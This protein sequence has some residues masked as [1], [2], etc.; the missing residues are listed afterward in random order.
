MKIGLVTDSLRMP[1]CEAVS[2][3]ASLGVDGIQPYVV[4]GDMAAWTMGTTRRRELRA[5]VVDA[6]LEFASVCGDL[7]GGF[8][9]PEEHPWRI[10]RTKHILDLAAEW[11]APVVTSHIGVVPREPNATRETLVRAMRAVGVHAKAAG[12]AY[13][14]ETGP[15]PAAVLRGFLEEVADPWIKVNYDPANMV[16][17]QGESASEAATLLAPYLVHTHA[18][19]GRQNRRLEANRLYQGFADLDESFLKTLDE[20]FVELPLG[21]GSV[22]FPRYLRELRRLGYD[23]YLTIER[24]AGDHRCEDV[25]NAVASLRGWLSEQPHQK[26]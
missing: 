11:T 26:A 25:R 8:T 16:M 3:A 6:G 18:K 17:I 14:L 9:R 22:D 21:E 19:D 13:A 20:Y 23:G 2:F 4:S 7:G 10:D 15:E 5:Q 1:F 12:V 24:E